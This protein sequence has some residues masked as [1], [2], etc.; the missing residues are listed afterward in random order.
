M[1]FFLIPYAVLIN[2]LVPTAEISSRLSEAY[3]SEVKTLSLTALC[4]YTK[5]LLCQHVA[6]AVRDQ[7]SLPCN[8]AKRTH[9][10]KTAPH[11]KL[12]ALVCKNREKPFYF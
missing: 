11:L 2:L 8:R 4:I 1:Y 3:R 5:P 6:G 7:V 10:L 9:A 12:Q